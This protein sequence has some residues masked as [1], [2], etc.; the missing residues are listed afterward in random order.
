MVEHD[1]LK[2]AASVMSSLGHEVRLSL[3]RTLVRSGHDGMSFQSLVETMEVPPST[4]THHLKMLVAS[5]LVTQERN[6]RET[7]SRPVFDTLEGVIAYLNN[8]CCKGFE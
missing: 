3:Y 7:I 4:L 5:G 2:H 6:G 8:E 1:A